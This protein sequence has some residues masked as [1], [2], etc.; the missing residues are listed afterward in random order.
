MDPLG[1]KTQCRPSNIVDD[2]LGFTFENL[3]PCMRYDI[4]VRVC[5]RENDYSV[6]AKEVGWRGPDDDACFSQHWYKFT[7]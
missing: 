6:D 5:G 7:R 3:L 1:R 4:S 2:P